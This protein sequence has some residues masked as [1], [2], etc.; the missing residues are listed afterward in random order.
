MCF[1]TERCVCERVW[2]TSHD[3]SVSNLWR[4]YLL[5]HLFCILLSVSLS[6]VPAR[7]LFGSDHNNIRITNSW[8]DTHNVKQM[9]VL[10][11]GDSTLDQCSSSRYQSFWWWSV[12]LKMFLCSGRQSRQIF[13]TKSDSFWNFYPYRSHLLLVLF[14]TRI[15]TMCCFYIR[16]N[17]MCC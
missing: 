15:T 9:P 7:L 17:D 3:T 8:W 13:V 16:K 11:W 5:I 14:Q 6:F 12:L 4:Q 2:K 1:V 10:S